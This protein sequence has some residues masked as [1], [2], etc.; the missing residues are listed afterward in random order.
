MPK[1]LSL[2]I[3][4]LLLILSCSKNEKFTKKK[5]NDINDGFY[6]Q[7]KYIVDDLIESVLD[8]TYCFE[9]INTLLGPSMT[10]NLEPTQ[11]LL[12]FEIETEWG[13]IDPNWIKVLVIELQ[14]D[15]CYKN[16]YIK[17]I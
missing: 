1:K 4:L 7:R 14:K 17:N 5:W 9:S 6:L 12:Y 11:V 8:S 15:S 10:P 13:I 3:L 2:Y 16:A